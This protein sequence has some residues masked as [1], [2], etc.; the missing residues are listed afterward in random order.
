MSILLSYQPLLDILLISLGFAYSQQIVLRAGVFS[1]ATAGFASVGAYC[2]AI[3]AKTY[4]VPWFIALALSLV[5]GGLIGWLLAVPLSRLR[6][7]YQAIATLA[8][9]QIVTSIMLI[10]EPIT[11]GGFGINQIP[12][13]ITTWHLLV[14]GAVVI[15][16][17]R[18]LKNSGVGRAFDAIQQDETV[19]AVLGVSIRKYHALAFMIS[20]AIGGLYGG[21]ESLHSYSLTPGQY[22]FSFAVTVLAFIVVGGRR[23]VIGPVIGV[24]FLSLL[25]EVSRPFAEYRPMITGLIMVL[26]MNYTPLG[27]ADTVLIW[28]RRVR[29]QRQQKSAMKGAGYVSSGT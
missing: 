14:V 1:I 19:G 21:L 17:M 5:L 13:S 3:L 15:Y 25:P 27:L 9:V 24:A 18:S 2:A 11:G 20:G 12:K 28:L 22:S 10:A 16:F 6:G 4:G 23:T 26:V 8:F 29:A 7:I